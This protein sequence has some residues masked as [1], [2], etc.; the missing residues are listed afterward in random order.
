M[1][2]PAPDSATTVLLTQ[3][4]ALRAAAQEQVLELGKE[5]G[6]L[7]DNDSLLLPLAAAAVVLLL[8]LPC[9]V[10]ACCTALCNRLLNAWCRA[11]RFVVCQCCGLC[12]VCGLCCYDGRGKKGQ[13][14]AIVDAEYYDDADS[15]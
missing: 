12:G 13:G 8:L 7:S 3:L 9:L 11:M 10:I 2:T 4:D 1:A 5:A 15:A 6:V 14:I